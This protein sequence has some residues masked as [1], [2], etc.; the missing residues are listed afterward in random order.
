MNRADAP[1]CTKVAGG[2]MRVTNL[3]RISQSLRIWEVEVKELSKKVMEIK[4]A[5]LD[6]SGQRQ[7]K[8]K[9]K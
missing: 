6:E 3:N 1:S 4:E 9:W 2:L 8:Q 5:P 7:K